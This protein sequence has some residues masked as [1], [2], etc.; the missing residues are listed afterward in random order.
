M[1]VVGWVGWDVRVGRGRGGWMGAVGCAWVFV[2]EWSVAVGAGKMGG[3]SILRLSF[4]EELCG[5][6]RLDMAR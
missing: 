2:G 6:E 5:R 3:G 4:P 1:V